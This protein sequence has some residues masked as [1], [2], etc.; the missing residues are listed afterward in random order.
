MGAPQ[1]F[2]RKVA[3]NCHRRIL[4]VAI[5]GLAKVGYRVVS[6]LFPVVVLSPQIRA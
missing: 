3:V 5:Y 2:D 1:A 4:L 6:G